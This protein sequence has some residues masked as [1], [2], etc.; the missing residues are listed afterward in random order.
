MDIGGDLMDGSRAVSEKGTARQATVS[1]SYRW[2]PAWGVLL[3]SCVIV[4]P[5]ASTEDAARVESTVVDIEKSQG[6]RESA[7][8]A[9]AQEPRPKIASPVPEAQ[10]P[11]PGNAA[12]GVSAQSVKGETE[13]VARS[14]QAQKSDGKAT[15]APQLVLP[16]DVAQKVGHKIWLNETGGNR[17]AVTSWNA[18]EDFASLGVGH[19]IWF[20]AGNPTAFEESFP[21]LLAFL[22]KQG[23]HL[24][25][26]LDKTPIPHCPWINRAE[27]KRNFNSPEMQQLRQFLLATV[28]G[29]IQFL[30]ARAQG[31]IDKI[32]ENTPDVAER[33]HIVVQFSRIVQAS[34]DLYPLIDYINFKGEGTN[35]AETAVNRQTGNRQ[36]W[37]LKQVLLSMNG[38]SSD[39]AAVLAEF[40]DAAQSVLQQRV[41]NL[42]TNHIWEAGWLRRVETYRRPIADLDV[43]PMRGRKRVVAREDG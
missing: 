27:F 37:G 4:R 32:L 26:W 2:G 22:R 14:P 29:Q 39:R 17:N 13:G 16:A 30:V 9:E 35:P 42:P 34:K 8:A 41:R 1:R 5:A 19:F 33:E 18:N 21:A 28:P 38:T 25:P 7:P 3:L 6:E 12:P 24:P 40:T 23:A 15:A 36:G 31:A 43:S 10:N 11:T 20:P